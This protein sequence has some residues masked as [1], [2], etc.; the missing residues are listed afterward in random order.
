V[1]RESGNAVISG[2]DRIELAFSEAR[3][4]IDFAGQSADVTARIAGPDIGR[5]Q[6]E[7]DQL[8]GVEPDAH[9]ALGGEQLR[10]ADA[11]NALHEGSYSIKA[12]V[13]NQGQ[14]TP[15]S[16]MTLSTVRSITQNANDGSLTLTTLASAA[17]ALGKRVNLQLV[18]A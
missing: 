11:G 16:V 18:P 4:Q 10:L 12:Q 6:A 1:F 17:A 8:G 3:A 7:G 14:I 2:E 5:L 13:A 9:G 15:G